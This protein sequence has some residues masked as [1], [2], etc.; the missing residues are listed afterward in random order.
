MKKITPCLWFDNQLEEA[1]GFYISVFPD[2]EILNISRYP[3]GT[4][5]FAG[6]VLTATFR[7]SGHE[8]IALNGGPLFKFTEAVSFS[9]DCKTQEEVDYYWN[10][11]SEGGEESMCG[12]LKD[13]FGLSWQV[14][15]TELGSWI[16]HQDPEKAQ[17]AMQALFKMR[18]IDIET[19][20]RAV[21]H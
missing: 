12:W 20:I 15:P 2:S 8:F 18:K 7:L 17:R 11:L 14:V 3:E 21:G 13:K 10:K 4:P 6:K 5:D 1:I 19:I 9:V 16:S